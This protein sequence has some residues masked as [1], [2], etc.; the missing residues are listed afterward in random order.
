MTFT[1]ELEDMIK[2]QRPTLSQRSISNY[3]GTIKRLHKSLYKTTDMDDLEWLLDSD[4]V[5]NNIEGQSLNSR[6]TILATIVTVLKAYGVEDQKELGPY[7]TEMVELAQQYKEKRATGAKSDRQEENWMEFPELRKVL[8]T[9]HKDLA[10]D[11]IL[12]KDKLNKRDFNRL[13]QY[14][15]ASMYVLDPESNP[16]VRLDYSM[17]IVKQSEY[18][19]MPEKEKLSDNYLVIDSKQKK[20]FSFGDYKTAKARGVQLIRVG[21][22]LNSLLNIWLKHNDGEYLFLNQRGNRMNADTMSKTLISF[23]RKHT[24]KRIGASMLR[25][26]YIS[27]KFPRHELDERDEVAEKMMHSTNEQHGYSKV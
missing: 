23:W 17:K 11:G 8:R 5:L 15:L 6:K 10:E 19:K 7:E 3:V 21:K 4:K 14:V 24:G 27:Y 12:T 26:I 18:D 2:A 25:N 22:A 1:D 16:P 9:V 20:M 13:Q